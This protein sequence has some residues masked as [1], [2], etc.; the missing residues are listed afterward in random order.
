MVSGLSVFSC[1]KIEL[2]LILT[3]SFG[4]RINQDI[5]VVD[6]KPGL[7]KEAHIYYDDN[8][9]YSAILNLISTTYNKNSYYQIQLLESNERKWYAYALFYYTHYNSIH[10]STIS[11]IGCLDHGVASQLSLDRRHCDNSLICIQPRNS[12]KPT[13]SI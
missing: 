5:P 9:K 12:L 4:F 3:H 2:L 1:R 7:E 11:V 13:F 6:P 8:S 10:I